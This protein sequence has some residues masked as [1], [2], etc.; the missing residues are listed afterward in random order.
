MAAVAP[1]SG[2]VFRVERQRGDMWFAKYRL[3]DGRQV[4][5][6]TGLAWSDRGR[7][8]SGYY[9]KRLAEDWLRQVLDEARRGTLAEVTRSGATFADAAAEWL[10]FIE[11]DRER[12]PSTLNDYRSALRAHLLPAFGERPLE[13]ITTEDIERWRRSVSGLS[14]RSKNK[15]LIQ[16][17]GI[18]RRAQIDR[19]GGAGQSAGPG[20]EASDAT[21]RRHSGV[22][23]GVFL[24]GLKLRVRR[25]EMINAGV[26]GSHRAKRDPKREP[27]KP[28]VS[29]A[30]ISAAVATG[31]SSMPLATATPS[32]ASRRLP[33]VARWR[34]EL[35]DKNSARGEQRAWLEADLDQPASAC[36][37]VPRSRLY[38]LPAGYRTR[39]RY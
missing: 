35:L 2:H 34:S 7:P 31:H 13:E 11:E 22:L 36:R 38:A 30:R 39:W 9:T 5:K 28:A 33:L 24:A 15:L 32:G 8:P 1:P 21:E 16:L 20:G 27:A 3:P 17:H 6:E 26:A 12:K 25:V 29:I 18:F 14:N 4:Q 23:P 19:V 10:R 37:R